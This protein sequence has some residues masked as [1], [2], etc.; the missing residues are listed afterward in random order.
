MFRQ[1][2]PAIDLFVEKGTARVPDDGKFHVI[3]QGEIRASFRGK[4][5]AITEYKRIIEEI[6]YTPPKP[7]QEDKSKILARESIERDL[8][9]IASYWDRAESYRTGGKL[10]YR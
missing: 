10:R 8:D 2:F 6:G 5:R 1:G 9:R 4:S 3:Y 7:K